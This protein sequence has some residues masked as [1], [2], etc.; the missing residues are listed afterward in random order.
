MTKPKKSAGRPRKGTGLCVVSSV[1]APQEWWEAINGT[2]AAETI[3]AGKKVSSSAVVTDL[4]DKGLEL[5]EFMGVI[6]GRLRAG[7]LSDPKEAITLADQIREL[8]A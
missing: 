7:D 4:V 6:E 1:S 2:A 3:M 5:S 8:L